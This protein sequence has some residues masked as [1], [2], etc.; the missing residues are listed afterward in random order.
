MKKIGKTMNMKVYS[1]FSEYV[2]SVLSENENGTNWNVLV[3]KIK[4]RYTA[5][6]WRKVRSLI[7]HMG[8]TN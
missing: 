3:D 4:E 5:D 6:D 1:E 8:Y 2:K 7:Q